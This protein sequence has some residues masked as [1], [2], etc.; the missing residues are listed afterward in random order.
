[1][2]HTVYHEAEIP[3]AD[4][5]RDY[6]N[7]EA[8]LSA[9][10]D[11]EHYNQVWSCPDHAFDVLDFWRRFRTLHLYV[12]EIVF[13]EALVAE[14]ETED[15]LQA[16]LHEV[17]PKEKRRLVQR[18]L[19]LEKTR[20]GSVC[21]SAG[22]SCQLCPEGCSKPLH[23]PCRHPEAMRYALE[24]LGGNVCKTT[25]TLLNLPL[26]WPGI[27]RLPHHLELVSGILLP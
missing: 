10:Q 23:Q 2:Y 21:L 14:V 8:F 12:L 11:C 24:A 16:V 5:V 27:G 13:S 18:M 1:M 22:G 7:V 19:A 4:Y 6:V 15:E 26:E 20:P 25:E 3:V 17:L 9:C